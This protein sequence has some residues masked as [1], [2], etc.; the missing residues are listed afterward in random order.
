MEPW[1]TI[2]IRNLVQEECSDPVSTVRGSWHWFM[3]VLGLECLGGPAV[4]MSPPRSCG[5]HPAAHITLA[6]AACV[7]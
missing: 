3:R 2:L 6:I 1:T 4:S 7:E 5:D